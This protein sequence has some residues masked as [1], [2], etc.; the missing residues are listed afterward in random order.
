MNELI[1]YT[2]LATNK[3]TGD[4]IKVTYDKKTKQYKQNFFIALI[5]SNWDIKPLPVTKE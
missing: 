1:N 2:H 5:T 3:K 4:I